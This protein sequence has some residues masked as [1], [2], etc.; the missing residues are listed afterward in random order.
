MKIN[1]KLKCIHCGTV[2]ECNEFRC[3]S[4]CSCGKVIIS[5]ECVTE[6]SLGK[7][8]I[9]VSAKLLNE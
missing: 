7:D 1:K 6:G 2:V 9:D 3:V 8:Y 4:K 5:G